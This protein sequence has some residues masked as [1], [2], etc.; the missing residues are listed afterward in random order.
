MQDVAEVGGGSDKAAEEQEGGAGED[1][2]E[3]AGP[4][5]GVRTGADC[6]D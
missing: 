2:E 4:A 5:V 6:S 1:H 3:G